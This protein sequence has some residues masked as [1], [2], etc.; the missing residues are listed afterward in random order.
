MHP[1]CSKKARTNDDIGDV[2]VVRTGNR[3]TLG[4]FIRRAQRTLLDSPWQIIQVMNHSIVL[5]SASKVYFKQLKYWTW[6]KL[7]TLS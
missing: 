1:C 2:G 5:A 7:T 6:A 3:S 4:G